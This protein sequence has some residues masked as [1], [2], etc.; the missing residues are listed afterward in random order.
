[1]NVGS[2]ALL[3]SLNGFWLASNYSPPFCW[4][5]H[6]GLQWEDVPAGRSNFKYKL[7]V[8]PEKR[9]TGWELHIYSEWLLHELLNNVLN[10]FVVL[11]S[12]LFQL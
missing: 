8:L 3:S 9:A 1:M 5:H 7:Y 6:Q 10:E 12:Y 2:L 11:F 4:S